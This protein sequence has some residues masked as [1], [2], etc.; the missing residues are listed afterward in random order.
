MLLAPLS[1]ASRAWRRTRLPAQVGNRDSGKRLYE[2]HTCFFC[3]SRHRR[4]GRRRRRARGGGVR[5][6]FQGFTRYVRQ[7]RGQMPAFTDKILSDQDVADIF[8]Y[9]RSLPAAKPVKDIPLLE[10]VEEE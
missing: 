8:A 10:S 4:S 6:I 3:C 5:E 1:P 9:I 7:P 2:K